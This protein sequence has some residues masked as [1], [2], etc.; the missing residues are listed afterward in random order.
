M[1]RIAWLGKKTDEI[2][3]NQETLEGK[4][5]KVLAALDAE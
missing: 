2:L 3:K 4:L 5:D 1:E